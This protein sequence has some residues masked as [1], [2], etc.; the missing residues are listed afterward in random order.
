MKRAMKKSSSRVAWIAGTAV[1]AAALVGGA[2]L[3]TSKSA[4][5]APAPPSPSPSPA[6]GPSGGGTPTTPITN[7][8]LVQTSQNAL[9]QVSV[10]AKVPGLAYSMSQAAA[11]GGN[12]SAP[13]FVQQLIIFQNYVNGLGGFLPQGATQALSLNTAG[14]LDYA[15]AGALLAVATGQALNPGG[16]IAHMA[17]PPSRARFSQQTQP[18]HQYGKAFRR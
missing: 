12:P 5:A 4:G 9:A 14:T 15:T 10:T 2:I 17:P 1:G 3:L 18:V 16:A 13:T 6:P 11:D 7:P 8:L